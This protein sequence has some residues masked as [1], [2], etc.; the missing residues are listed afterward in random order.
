MKGIIKSCISKSPRGLAEDRD[1]RK[2]I[3]LRV[4]AGGAF[5]G[6]GHREDAQI[7]GIQ[8]VARVGLGDNRG[9]QQKKVLKA[10]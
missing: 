10:N 5:G 8:R 4:Q 9:R 7:C 2:F 1:V 6:G 3:S